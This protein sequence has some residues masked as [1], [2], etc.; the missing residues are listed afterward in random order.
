M[1]L[2]IVDCDDI[3]WEYIRQLRTDPRVAEG[4]IENSPISVEQQFNYMKKY[5][6]NY[7]VVLLDNSPVG[8]FGVIKDDIR[9]CVHPDFQHMGIGKFIIDECVKI[10]PQA[11]AKIK[12][13]NIKSIKLFESAGFKLK[14]LIFEK[15]YEKSR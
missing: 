15:D 13:D 6:K 5:S 4:F 1:N 9:V 14:Y 2:K 11:Y 3:Y 7:R 12:K 8:Y 10:W